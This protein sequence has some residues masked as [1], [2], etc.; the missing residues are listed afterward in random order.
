MDLQTMIALAKKINDYRKLAASAKASYDSAQAAQAWKGLDQT[1]AQLVH[2]IGDPATEDALDKYLTEHAQ[3]FQP[4]TPI[5]SPEYRRRI[6]SEFLS[7]MYGDMAADR[8]QGYFDKL[9]RLLY[10]NLTAGEVVLLRQGI[11]IESKVDDIRRDVGIIK[12]AVVKD[13]TPQGIHTSNQLYIDS[14]TEPLFLH[15]NVPGTKVNLKN[16]FV[17]PRFDAPGPIADYLTRFVQSD[18]QFLFIEGDAG[19]GKSSLAAYLSYYCWH[20]EDFRRK[21]FGDH[22]FFAVRLRDIEIPDKGKDSQRLADGLYQFMHTSR[23]EL[24]DLNPV[25]FLDGYD[26]LCTIEQLRDPQVALYGLR[27]MGC[28]III[29]TRPKY[30]RIWGFDYPYKHINL[31]HF[32]SEQRTKWLESYQ[33]FCKEQIEEKNLQYLNQYSSEGICDTPMGVYM[34][35]AGR[36]EDGELNNGWALYHRIFSQELGETAYS[37]SR[38]EKDNFPEHGIYTPTYMELLYQV[39]EE[40]AYYLYQKNNADLLMPDEEVR[41]VVKSLG[42]EDSRTEK[43]VSD[44][45]ALCDYWKQHTDRGCVEFYH[46]NIRD[47]FLCEKIMDTWNELYQEYETALRDDRADITPLLKKLCEMFQHG[48]LEDTVLSFIDRRNAYKIE[49]D[50]F[51]KA[52]K[53]NRFLP[54]IFETLL[55]SGSPYPVRKEENPVNIV[56]R[57]LYD[58]ERV[59]VPLYHQF[60]QSNERIQWWRDVNKVN[61]DGTFRLLACLLLRYM[62]LSDL[63][64]A[65][66]SYANMLLANLS[67]AYL[68]NADLSGA[69]LGDAYLINAN[70]IHAKL[71][72]ANLNGADLRNADLRGAIL[73]GANLRDANLSG[74]NLRAADLSY[75]DLRNANLRGADLCAAIVI[76]ASMN[77]CNLEGANLDGCNL[78]DAINVPEKYLPNPSDS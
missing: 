66:L 67:G 78:Q 8:I 30:I 48:K 46:N 77:Q 27:S 65:D 4:D 10:V 35:A 68:N 41:Q 24:E 64:N 62:P 73:G 52:E 11:S 17:E 55:T 34:V 54:R 49:R 13:H 5:F 63:H 20:D 14:F 51:I 3:G 28:K 57:V 33:T 15:K 37:Q 44:C 26:E 69:Y 74:A 61:E 32:N 16:L 38:S 25:L 22:P 75:A 21:V 7:P 18:A 53:E 9:E 76:G 12:E 40:L 70:L 23:H 72:N 45:Y 71:N 58:I 47:F 1:I 19:C 31:Q 50:I 60:L 59:Y 6:A 56:R 36:F 43:I 2:G 42:I 39:S 29:T